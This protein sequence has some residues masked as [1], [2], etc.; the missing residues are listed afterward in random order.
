MLMRCFYTTCKQN[1]LLDQNIVNMAYERYG[2]LLQ[3]EQYDED[4]INAKGIHKINVHNDSN[5][6]FAL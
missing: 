6:E 3:N 2:I 5:G 4:K 1:L